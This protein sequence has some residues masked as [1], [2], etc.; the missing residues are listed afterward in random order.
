MAQNV[1]FTSLK[2]WS[3]IG[4][5][6]WFIDIMYKPSHV[7]KVKGHK[8]RAKVMWG[9]F[10]RW[11]KDSYLYLSTN[12]SHGDPTGVGS[13]SGL[14]LHHSQFA[15]AGDTSS[16][17]TA[18]YVFVVVVV[19]VA[20]AYPSSYNFQNVIVIE[21]YGEIMIID[22]ESPTLLLLFYGVN[23]SMNLRIWLE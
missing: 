11:S 9:Q 21:I 18:K 14:S 10:V 8:C 15:T 5:K 23:S 19:V 16:P 7:H 22:H 1:K 3:Q 4:I 6:T 12:W 13:W 20:L 17:G 2:S